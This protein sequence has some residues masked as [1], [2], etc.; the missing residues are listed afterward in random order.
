MKKAI[1]LIFVYAICSFTISY[2]QEKLEIEGAIIIRNSE[3]QTPVAGT[4]RYNPAT[5]DF[6][7]FNG[8]WVS[9]SNS[10]GPTGSGMVTDI[11]GNQY[12]TITIDTQTWMRE[13]LRVTKY[14]NGDPVPEV[15]LNSDWTGLSTGAWS[16]NDHNP[17]LDLP[18]GKLYNWYAVN[19]SRGLCPSGWHVPT[20]A[21]WTTLTDSLGGLTVA[22]GKMKTKGTIQA[23]T[24]Y[25]EDP[26]AGATNE[27][28]FTGLPGGFRDLNG[29]FHN[30]GLNTNWWSS[31]EYDGSNAW[32]RFLVF[33]ND[34]VGRNINNKR[35]GFSVRCVKD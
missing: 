16:W 17:E 27:S 9:L 29:Q 15:L 28:G 18:F 7:G 5:K 31:N 11:D 12:L 24:G 25:W 14:R 13:D 33:G 30:L 4:I 26:N 1:L 10:S 8:K 34:D 2:S 35:L 21:E 6:E 3:D 20:D 19:D 23:G 32:Y 22:G